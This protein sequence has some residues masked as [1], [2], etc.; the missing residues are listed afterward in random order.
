[1]KALITRSSI[2]GSVRAPSSKSYTLRGLMCSALTNGGSAIAQPLE[3]DDTLAACDVLRKIGV[4]ITDMKDTW[5]VRGGRFRQPETDLFCR[6]SAGTLRFMTAICALVPGTSRLTAGPSLARRPIGPLAEALRRLGVDCVT[7][8]GMP[9]VL[10]RGGKLGGGTIE[11]AGDISSQFISALMFIAPLTQNG[12]DIVL[13]SRPESAPYIIMT[14]D[15]MRA[16]GVSAEHD[17]DF[18]RISVR[19]QQYEPAIYSV[20]GDWSSASYLLALGAV[21]GRTEVTNLNTNSHQ[22]DAEISRLL[23]KMGARVQEGEGATTVLQSKLKPLRADLSDCIDL[24]PTLCVL[25]AVADGVSELTGIKRARL[26]ESNRVAAMKEGLERMGIAV[27][28]KSDSLRI[29]GAT[30]HKAVIDSKGDHRV[31]M[32]FSILGVL[33]GDTTVEGAECV[34]KTYPAF[35]DVLSS[36]GGKVKLNE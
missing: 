15:C 5:M 26:K 10:V 33:A 9:P 8:N 21:A 14:R 13:T 27:E 30:P 3:A 22:A 16:F 4:N 25:A 19:P 28:E 17:A 18:T 23:N 1:M 35:W 36:L 11:L 24:L 29:T 12:M 7:H 34:A 6:D 2:D 31:A 20:E 32:A